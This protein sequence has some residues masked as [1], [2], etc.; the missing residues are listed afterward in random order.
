MSDD[1]NLPFAVEQS[2]ILLI[3]A[4]LYL[5]LGL[6]AALIMMGANAMVLAYSLDNDI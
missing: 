1:S 6:H 3:C 4:G 5:W 2:G